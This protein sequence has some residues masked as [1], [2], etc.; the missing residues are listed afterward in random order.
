MF[1]LAIFQNCSKYYENVISCQYKTP[2]QKTSEHLPHTV[3][4]LKTTQKLN[5]GLP[6]VISC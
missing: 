1:K 5:P 4:R 3:M 2:L 6:N